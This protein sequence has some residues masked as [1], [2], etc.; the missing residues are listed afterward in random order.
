MKKVLK[1]LKFLF[2]F[3]P[4]FILATTTSLKLWVLRSLTLDSET[5]KSRVSVKLDSFKSGSVW[6]VGADTGSGLECRV[7]G[8]PGRRH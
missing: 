7:T 1:C 6:E 2:C 8:R 3:V 5:S 4:E